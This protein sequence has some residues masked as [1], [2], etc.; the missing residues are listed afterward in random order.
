MPSSHQVHSKDLDN[1][2]EITIKLIS[3]IATD[4]PLTD[5]LL[6]YG[7]DSQ[8]I[9]ACIIQQANEIHDKDLDNDGEITTKLISTITTNDPITNTW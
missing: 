1:D 2:G 3:T 5:A 7:K 4:E 8:Q 9:H 6:L